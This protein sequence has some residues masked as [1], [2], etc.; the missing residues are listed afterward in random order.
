MRGIWQA[1][2][3]V[4]GLVSSTL[5]A[6]SP[7][8]QPLE[9]WQGWVLKGQ[10]FRSCPFIASMGPG[11][12]GAHRCAWPGTLS[13]TLG[14]NGGEF[15]QAWQIYSDTW[16]TLPG[17]IEHWPR[18]V[19]INGTA[20]AVVA[21]NGQPQLRLAT[22]SH[23]ITGRFSWNTRPESLPVSPQ[24]ALVDLTLDGKAVEQPER[25]GGAVWLGQ[26]RATVERTQLGKQ[27][28]RL[29]QDEI[30]ALLVTRIRL[31]VSGEGREEVLGVAL[32]A[33]FTPLDLTGDLPARIENDGQLRVQLRP[34]SF[35]LTLTAR[36]SAVAGR[37]TRPAAG[38]SWP[39]EE[40]WS[41]AGNDRLRVAAVEGAEAIDPAQANVPGEWQEYPAFRVAG[42]G[43]LEIVERSRGL[44]NLDDNQLQLQ[45]DLWLDFNHEGYTVVDHIN[46]ALHR[47]WRLDMAAPYQLQSARTGE[48]T[49]LVTQGQ[50]KPLSGIELRDM[51]LD[52]TATSRLMPARGA[53]PATGWTTRFDSVRGTLHLPPG[54][55][56]LGAPG[57]D[58]A[59]GSW[60]SGWGLWN[61][62]GVLIVIVF[63]H[64][65][66]GL[67]PAVI[68]AL[69]LALM[70]QESPSLIWLWANLI[71]AIAVARAVPAG[72]LRRYVGW[73]RIASFVVL[74]LALLPL[75]LVQLRLA[76]F[77][78]LDAGGGRAYNIEAMASEEALDTVTMAPPA[79]AP[80]PPSPDM[81]TVA[82]E[83]G[84]AAGNMAEE[85]YDSSLS[86]IVVTASRKANVS[87][88]YA[89]G[90]LLQ[91]GPG[92]P[93][94]NYRDYPYSWS[95]PVD[96]AQTV[97]FIVITPWLLA[98]WRIAGVLL[99]IAWLLLLAEAAWRQRSGAGPEGGADNRGAD[100][101]DAQAGKAPGGAPI[102]SAAVGV[103]V[104][105]LLGAMALLA[106]AP[107]AQAQAMP[108]PELLAELRTRLTEAPKCLP[109][110]VELTS[111]SVSANGNRLQVRLS[112][113]ALTNIAV[114]L[115]HASDRWQIDAVQRNGQSALTIGREGDGSLWMPLT[116]GVH[117]ITL[118]GRLASADAIQLTFPQPPRAV[119]VSVDGWEAN[120]VN[121]G[122]LVSGS[123]ELVR[124]RAAA[125][126]AAT[127]AA[128]EF[129]AFVSVT[130]AVQL[131]LDW[132]IRTTVERIA[133]RSA[134]LQ[135]E[136]PLLAGESVL[137]D[138]I[139][140]R[141]NSRV[142][143]G[144]GRGEGSVA[145][146][147]ALL[148]SEALTLTLPADAAR[149]ERWTFTVNPQWHIAFDGLPASL[150]EDEGQ[151]QWVYHYTPRAG[152]TLKVT[153][154]RPEAVAG[155]TLAF[156]EVNYGTEFGKRSLTARL[157]LSYRSTQGG[158]HV[159]TLPEAARVTEVTVDDQPVPV[160]PEKGALPLSLL[161]GAH[162]VGIT[163]T[164]PRGPGFVAQPSKVD[165]AHPASNLSTTVQLPGDRWTLY[166]HGP[167]VGPALMYW[168]ELIVFLALAWALGRV[169][170]SPLKSWEW[171]LLGLGLSTQ[172]WY[173]FLGMVVWVF[174][175]HWR[176]R[177]V[178]A[179][180]PWHVFNAVQIVLGALTFFAV[181]SL[182]FT[183][184]RYGLLA[185]P[186]MSLIGPN[187]DYGQYHWFLD[188]T[189][190]TLAQPRVISLPIWVYKTL[191]FGWAL[192]IA[193]ALARW[194]RSAWQAWT[195]GGYWR[196][197]PPPPPRRKPGAA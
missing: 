36:G 20:A 110:C 19:R 105:G 85:R 62:F 65:V 117:D 77:P 49:L 59:P 46:G 167:G 63:T 130:R 123:I 153:I 93:R 129:P 39:A 30:P 180:K 106:A 121:N 61:L 78:Q 74:A 68:A 53:A 8:P 141:D 185:S 115:P 100:R 103:G 31:Q 128:S 10:E 104:I 43:S 48:D 168:A 119:S 27:V 152:E 38:G 4:A 195:R 144:I 87:Q 196:E 99:T 147:S 138:G 67:V 155:S 55:R 64:W 72:A 29:L 79:A 41:F 160:R 143:V 131:D 193:M 84:R 96:A 66:G 137:T 156:D 69:A 197:A 107:A 17:N 113:S 127:L 191:M 54:H 11:N 166:V 34:G 76:F 173:V 47:D 159:I 189:D 94:W 71:G 174:A 118:E 35:E 148:R 179:G 177:W 26:R 169:S 109:S 182:V 125:D 111:A 7:V 18:E 13:L 16:V 80:P 184:I 181:S 14:A 2:A 133:P 161:P 114:A 90:T 60:V 192:W 57:T 22:G 75:L 172:S 163:W 164:E 157:Q 88:R 170:F 52:L 45:R 21:R 5:Q 124:R 9:A 81:P 91:T 25:P 136:V 58:E 23:A 140:L 120:G 12:E 126:G 40:I 98:V 37:V 1:L 15:R 178:H 183:G 95:G 92:V 186:D 151:T 28:Y 50:D 3:V 33:G 122:R 51:Q 82:A 146:D 42:E 83:E 175:M 102:T 108:S 24:T 135:V 149:T 97:R 142:L 190:A 134:P 56:L 132:T 176:E 73:Y 86:D 194:L 150:P 188:R 171:L 44:A 187:S 6:A 70:Y 158:R 101:E 32:P 162:S 145:W 89:S 154:T 165:I 139:E 112:V 116:P